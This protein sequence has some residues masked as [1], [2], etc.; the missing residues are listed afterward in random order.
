M[1]QVYIRM[2]SHEY[3]GIIQKMFIVVNSFLPK[4]GVFS[5]KL[6]H[7][8]SIRSRAQIL[9]TRYYFSYMII[10]PENSK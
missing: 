6:F 3:K 9:L 1:Y 8:K 5:Q 7:S 10:M 2:F 4:H